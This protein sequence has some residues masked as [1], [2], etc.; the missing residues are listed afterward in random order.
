MDAEDVETAEGPPIKLPKGATLIQ[1]NNT[2]G[3]KLP[4]GATLIPDAPVKKKTQ[5]SG[6]DSG[7]GFSML[8]NGESNSPNSN[9]PFQSG[10]DAAAPIV[11][12]A[13]NQADIQ[14]QQTAQQEQDFNDQVAATMA[15]DQNYQAT[16]HRIA[17][18][19]DIPP[20]TLLMLANTAKNKQTEAQIQTNQQKQDD[21]DDTQ[22]SNYLT[23]HIAIPFYKST[24]GAV[25]RI[26]AGAVDFISNLDDK[27]MDLLGV[28]QMGSKGPHLIKDYF[29]E[30][31][32]DASNIAP[33]GPTKGNDGRIG[34]FLDDLVGAGGTVAQVAVMPETEIPKLVEGAE[35]LVKSGA[36]SIAARTLYKSA[37]STITKLFTAQGGLDAY[38][39]SSINGGDLT[40]NLGEG[41]VGALKGMA[42]GMLMDTQMGAAASLSKN[43][44]TK[45]AEKGLLIGGK[46]T[47]ALL[48]SI[49]AGTV[50]GGTSVGENIVNGEPIDYNSAL[51]QGT[52]G[53]AFGIPEIATDIHEATKGN[54]ETNDQIA[55]VELMAKNLTD[56]NH[57]AIINN[58]MGFNTG[59]IQQIN[60]L[61]KTS[62]DLYAQSLEVGA[63]AY[64]ETD[65]TEKKNL[66][67]QQL[68]LKNQADVKK[69]TETIVKNPNEFLSGVFQSDLPVDEKIELMNKVS[70]INTNN[71]PVEIHKQNI[72]TQI[73]NLNA[74]INLVDHHFNSLPPEQ[75]TDIAKAQNFQ[76]KDKLVQERTVLGLNLQDIVNAQQTVQGSREAMKII[77][78]NRATE[79]NQ[80]GPLAH[81]V[82]ENL[83]DGTHDV[84]AN[85]EIVSQHPTT[86]DAQQR[87]VDLNRPQQKQI[88]DINN[89]YNQQQQPFQDA[90]QKGFIEAP[91]GKTLAHAEP[92]E[93]I[94]ETV[95]NIK[96]D[97]GKVQVERTGENEVVVTD[98]EDGKSK[99]YTIEEAIEGLGIKP[100]DIKK[101]APD[102]E[103]STDNRINGETTSSINNTEGNTSP[104]REDQNIPAEATPQQ[105]EAEGPNGETTTEGTGPEAPVEDNAAITSPTAETTNTESHGESKT[106]EAHQRGQ[107]GNVLADTAQEPVLEPTVKATGDVLDVPALKGS[108]YQ[109]AAVELK[110][111][112]HGLFETNSGKLI[113]K[114][115][116]TREELLQNFDKS[117]DKLTPEAIQKNIALKSVTD[118]I[119][120]AKVKGRAYEATLGI[121]V[122]AW[123][124]TLEI[125]AR[126]IEGGAKL[127]DAIRLGVNHIKQNY[128]VKSKNDKEIEDAV[129]NAFVEKPTR[130]D[131]EGI[132]DYAKRVLDWK[133]ALSSNEEL[134]SAFKREASKSAK[135]ETLFNTK[136]KNGVDLL[137]KNIQ[138]PLTEFNQA[139][140]LPEND[141]EHY[142]A[143]IKEL[144]DSD[145]IKKINAGKIM[146][147]LR[148]SNPKKITATEASLLKRSLRERE[149]AAGQGYR[150]AKA[151][152]KQAFLEYD[153][154]KKTEYKEKIAETKANYEGK[155]A[156]EKQAREDQKNELKRVHDSIRSQ[157][158]DI[159]DGLNK[160]KLL[161]GVDYSHRDLL[162]FSNHLNNIVT[163]KGID[164][165]RDYVSKAIDN[166]DH[167]RDVI[168]SKSLAGEAKNLLKQDYVPENIKRLI[169]DIVT[170]NP[171]RVEDVKELRSVLEDITK[172]QKEGEVPKNSERDL[173]DFIELQRQF[174]LSQRRSDIL[175]EH[176]DITGSDEYKN[177]SENG[178]N[179][180]F[181]HKQTL[182]D[183]TNKVINDDTTTYNEKIKQLGHIDDTLSGYRKDLNSSFDDKGNQVNTPENFLNALEKNKD[184]G[185]QEPTE[186]KR[187]NLENITIAKQDT[188]DP[189][190][191]G[192]SPE[193]KQSIETLQKVPL[194]GQ[195]ANTL[196]LFNNVVEN[197]LDNDNHSGMTIL[198][199]KAIGNSEEGAL[200]PVKYLEDNKVTP[201]SVLAK[202]KLSQKLVDLRL[203]TA[204]LNVLLSRFANND[205]QFVVDMNTGTHFSQIQN[206]LTKA[207]HE[208][209]NL[210]HKPLAE[211]FKEHKDVAGNPESIYKMQL[212]SF[213]NQSRELAS[214]LQSDK[215]LQ[216]RI[217]VVNKDIAL[218]ENGSA[219]EKTEAALEKKIWDE[220]SGK[221]KDK[222]G[223]DIREKGD[224]P[225]VK[226]SDIKGI[227]DFLNPGEKATYD[228]FRTADQQLQPA[229]ESVA[230]GLNKSYE[231]W[232]D[233][234]RDAYRTL[235]SGTV[236]VLGTDN[237]GFQATDNN[238][239]TGSDTMT[240][241]VKGDPLAQ[242]SGENQR[243]LN[244]NFMDA[245]KQNIKNM[246]YDIHTLKDR[247]IFDE[248]MKNKD[249]IDAIGVDNHQFYKDAAKNYVLNDIGLTKGINE[250]GLRMVKSALNIIPTLGTY[251][252]LLSLSQFVKQWSST[253]GNMTTY[254]NGNAKLMFGDVLPEMK[255]PAVQDLLK[256]HP[257]S[258]RA[259]TL[260]GL[261]L[262]SSDALAEKNNILTGGD[263]VLQTTLTGVE[264]FLNKYVRKLEQSG[265]KGEAFLAAPIRIGDVK[266]AEL[267]WVSSY[268]HYLIDRK[269]V[270][271][272]K[273][274]DWKKEAENPNKDAAAFAEH[275]TSKQLNENTK[276]GRSKILNSND[277]GSMILKN[278]VI[279]FGSF[280]IEKGQTMIEAFRT[281]KDSLIKDD[282]G[283]YHF[284]DNGIEAARVLTANLM[285]EIFYRA[286]RTGVSLT[287]PYALGHAFYAV[288]DKL[289]GTSAETEADKAKLDL[290]QANRL[291]DLPHKYATDVIGNYIFNAMPNPMQFETQHLISQLS[292]AAIGKKLFYEPNQ[293]VNSE[294]KQ[295]QGYGGMFSAAF[296]G[297]GDR[298]RDLYRAFADN[299]NKDKVPVDITPRQKA[300]IATDFLSDLMSLTG[301]NDAD[302]RRVI[303]N[304]R[305]GVDQELTT[306][307]HDPYYADENAQ[308]PLSFNGKKVLLKEEHQDYYEQQKA[309]LEKQY[310]DQGIPD[311]Q[312]AQAASEY[313]KLNLLQKF[314]NAV[315]NEGT[316]IKVKKK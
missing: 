189:N 152:T 246:L 125:I 104:N 212:F 242:K 181:V 127:A 218:K 209:N 37:T 93:R 213:I 188:L 150:R 72:N 300:I 143:A 138:L 160:S 108:P 78:Q 178:G 310:K 79:L 53:M 16:L 162:S 55:K 34:Q 205:T 65:L 203:Y 115:Y 12:D 32:D 234:M 60:S 103:P 64:D 312:A 307:F 293:S 269:I 228:V 44:A 255:N 282:D 295:N 52:L 272:F 281:L 174:D 20:Q 172:S 15:K 124:T 28:P 155:L 193:Q 225:D 235:G 126:A 149:Q 112:K 14:A 292:Q 58:L 62:D 136:V 59:E 38:H 298:A 274:I 304:M 120:G 191:S 41:S 206:G 135:P 263:G 134:S 141:I 165:F 238:I 156:K 26:G 220:F 297:E 279:P 25:D 252:Q 146:Q 175:D 117:K 215:E 313:A 315:V 186:S 77:E 42:Q 302:L 288:I 92:P 158:K 253:I 96:T 184:T 2:G 226:F 51:R 145:S 69:A 1:N 4:Q 74:Q 80:A 142:V 86:E 261:N 177:L 314:G 67:L 43:I 164:R 98:P 248:A 275:V 262:L 185:D 106:D 176:H 29:D 289:F 119:R 270:P 247:M 245:Q 13:Q 154:A 118:A 50:F 21:I 27:N 299:T 233:H 153:T 198:E 285:E 76:A 7:N 130:N 309:I 85:G 6:P 271:D 90:I 45:L 94:P 11:A 208:L 211:V 49:M 264:N 207:E 111:G 157:V 17:A 57:Q 116:D 169:R 144:Q 173:V 87:A 31:A 110:N 33:V 36:I 305:K 201:K 122:A 61:P 5:T 102:Y 56:L 63:K 159:L 8:T 39:A 260:A 284:K 171:Q 24:V 40:T 35:A 190:Q 237:L 231:K 254:L 68:S 251:K 195:D 19:G 296:D 257:I 230:T 291:T 249:L 240:Q 273:S 301:N 259:E 210:I 148:E 316:E 133:K 199:A 129:R 236:D 139:L 131:G 151:D 182:Q 192:L 196:R 30:A 88:D 280:G 268:S 202:N 197:V 71:N 287:I 84:V 290:Q 256:Q 286:I 109:L 163:E 283:K 194:K 114:L 147:S 243:V 161:A 99:K 180:N 113:S 128:T 70:I 10:E 265:N 18:Q 224:I 95:F 47:E 222:T 294:I 258:R 276:A 278:L 73:D 121:P 91:T 250:D 167:S 81:N 306:K 216:K 223:L 200:K 3:I 204:N 75:Q 214:D 241:R 221:I 137:K 46:P 54:K 187:D 23:N 82:I 308:K 244:L 107:E 66:Q 277:I 132:H 239:D 311:K 170:L 123:N 101:I 217:N 266:S 179:T 229:H 183:L 267:A 97:A 140:G 48:N 89:K 219:K 105:N 83:N 232:N 9:N 22:V 168:A 303:E 166:A 227:D 100:E